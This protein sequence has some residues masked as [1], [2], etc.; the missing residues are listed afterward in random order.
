[1]RQTWLLVANRSRARL[2]EVPQKGD[3][4]VEIA[5]F[6][7]VE[8][9]LHARDLAT[10]GSG[11]FFGKGE[12]D[13]GHSAGTEDDKPAHEANKFAEQLRDYLEKARTRNAFGALWIMAAPA[14]L[15]VLRNKLTHGVEAEVEFDVDKDLTTA[16]RQDILAAARRA[17]ASP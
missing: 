5:D 10:D 3:D 7:H 1:M 16:S 4:P 8:G 6:A 15:G 11:R 12:R 13:Q 17:R 14:F 2:F 9:R